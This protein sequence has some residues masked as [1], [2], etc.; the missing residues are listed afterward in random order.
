[1]KQT[2]GWTGNSEY[3][4]RGISECETHGT[5][6]RRRLSFLRFLVRYPIFILAFGPP[7]FRGKEGIDIT[8]GQVDIWSFLQA[9]L[10]CAVTFRTVL[11]LA[12]AESILIPKQIPSFIYLPGYVSQSL[13]PALIATRPIGCSACFI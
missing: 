5:P 13:S 1:M 4:T 10:L 9:G 8:Q 11:R 12:A 7:V 2:A 3:E 6:P